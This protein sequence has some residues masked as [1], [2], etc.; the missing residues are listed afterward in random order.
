MS[1]CSRTRLISL[2]GALLLAACGTS[3]RGLGAQDLGESFLRPR[4]DFAGRMQ[5]PERP[6]RQFSAG[7]PARI[8]VIGDSLAQGFGIFLDR[9]VNERGLT[10]VVANRARTSTGL[11]RS[12]FY[13]WPQAFAG[14]APGLRPDVIVVHFGS[15]DKQ[16]LVTGTGTIPQQ[17]AEWDAAYRAQIRRILDIAAQQRAVVYWLGP[18]PDRSASLNRHMTRI[19]PI[20]EAEARAVRAVYLPMAEFAAGANGEYAKTA[21]IDGKTVTIRSPD[22]SHFTGAGYYLVVDQLLND[23]ARRMPGM[24]RP[25]NV[26][27]A[28]IL[29]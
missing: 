24:F 6:L 10:A 13:D 27:L 5:L 26:A 29:Q 9:R 3:P 7:D 28:G 4:D 18:A 17:T 12:D 2:I 15:N 25:A 14:I 20:I 23:M 21:V 16:A 11:S 1:S 22:G 8:L 19:N